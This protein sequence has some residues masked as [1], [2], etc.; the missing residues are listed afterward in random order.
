MI[1]DLCC[2]VPDAVHPLD[3]LDPKHLS[4]CFAAPCLR[5]LLSAPAGSLF[6]ARGSWRVPAWGPCARNG[7]EPRSGGRVL[8]SV[9]SFASDS[10]LPEGAIRCGRRVLFHD[11]EGHFAA[12]PSILPLRGVRPGR[13]PDRRGRRRS[14]PVRRDRRLVLRDRRPCR[15]PSSDWGEW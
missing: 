6:H 10:S 3:A 7:E 4:L 1:H 14:L 8:R 9:R 15:R 12:R 11:G 2:P 13:R 5:V